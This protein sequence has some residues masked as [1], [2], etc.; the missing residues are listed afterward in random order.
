MLFTFVGCSG[1]GKNTIIKDLLEKRPLVYDLLPTVTT[2]GMR[3][4]ESQ[5]NPYKFVETKEEFIQMIESGE[6]YEHQEIHGDFYGGSWKLLNAK[7]DEKKVLLKDIDVLGSNTLKEKFQ[8]AFPVISLFMYVNDVEILI[9]R[10]RKRGEKEDR[11]AV[12]R[13]RFAMEMSLSGTGDYLINNIVREDTGRLVDEIISCETGKKAYRLADTCEAPDMEMVEKLTR[14]AAQG[15][16]MARVEMGFNGKE[17]LIL[18]GA[19]RYYA[20]LR[21]GA[22]IQKHFLNALDETIKA[23]EAIDAA[24]FLK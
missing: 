8:G 6:I 21:A 13:S 1:V 10:L 16:A 24:E 11:I 15:A 4:G 2:R 23:N 20:A 9:D 3:P 22:F 17:I 7:L 5:G 19:D 14:E 12:R 18:S